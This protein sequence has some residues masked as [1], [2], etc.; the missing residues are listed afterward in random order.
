MA[1]SSDRGSSAHRRDDEVGHPARRGGVGI[2]P[3]GKL[4]GPYAEPLLRGTRHPAGQERAVVLGQE[5]G[6]WQR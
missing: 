5:V 2:V 4:D 6:G 3:T 1:A